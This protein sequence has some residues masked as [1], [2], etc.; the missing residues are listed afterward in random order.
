MIDFLC[1]LV[2]SCFFNSNCICLMCSSFK[3]VICFY[4]CGKFVV[5]S[6]LVWKDL[7][8]VSVDISDPLLLNV[9]SYSLLSEYK[10]FQ[11]FCYIVSRLLF[12]SGTWFPLL[13][14]DLYFNL[15]I[16]NSW[17]VAL[18]IWF[19]AWFITNK[20]STNISIMIIFDAFYSRN[21]QFCWRN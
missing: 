7:L 4:S 1:F 17:L 2:I 21:K 20:F 9:S 13:F 19:D 3:I 12:A 16:W 11:L 15:T 10:V 14:I 5:L 18:L 6:N 8:G